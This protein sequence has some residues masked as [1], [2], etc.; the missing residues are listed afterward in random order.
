MELSKAGKQLFYV[1]FFDSDSRVHHVD[2]Q[3]FFNRVVARLNPD[4]ALFR[5]F[6]RVFDQVD[7]YLLQP[8]LVTHQVRKFVFEPIF[9]AFES[10]RLIGLEARWAQKVGC[11]S[12]QFNAFRPG[13]RL[14]NLFDHLEDIVGVEDVHSEG[15]DPLSDLTQVQHVVH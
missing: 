10:R 4:R 6:E 13:L 9:A 12:C 1:F 8:S 11:C 14:E 15:K 3:F 5:E 7:Q 2:D